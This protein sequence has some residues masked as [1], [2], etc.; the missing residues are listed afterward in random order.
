[1]RKT[2][3]QR[4][5]RR[6]SPQKATKEN[7]VNERKWQAII[8]AADLRERAI[9]GI[10]RHAPSV[11]GQFIPQACVAPPRAAIRYRPGA[12]ATRIKQSQSQSELGGQQRVSGSTDRPTG[13]A[14][15]WQPSGQL[16]TRGLSG[17]GHAHAPVTSGWPSGS[18]SLD[19]SNAR[20]QAPW[21]TRGSNRV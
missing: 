4:E 3:R 16:P 21:N 9:G 1:M 19:A 17:R 20:S 11:L 10:S 7:L 6:S 12:R 18:Q 2:S 15:V 13:R 8:C 5:R 14:T